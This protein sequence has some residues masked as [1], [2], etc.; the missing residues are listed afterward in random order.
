MFIFLMGDLNYQIVW[1]LVKTLVSFKSSFYFMFSTSN[2]FWFKEKFRIPENWTNSHC[3][4][5][6]Q[7][8]NF[9]GPCFTVV[10]PNTVIF[11]VNLI[12]WPKYGKIR[13]RKIT[14]IKHSSRNARVWCVLWF[15]AN[16][17]QYCNIID[18]INFKVWEIYYRK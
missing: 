6:A 3:T 5:S 12:I 18:I 8:R 2:S 9:S 1:Q 16:V 13:T 15:I 4:K 7:I 10:G 14:L 17:L 11:R